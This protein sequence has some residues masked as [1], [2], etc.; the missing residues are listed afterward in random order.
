KLFKKVNTVTL[1][2]KKATVKSIK[3]ALKQMSSLKPGSLAIIFLAGHGVKDERTGKYYYLTRNSRFEKPATAGLDW[4]IFQDLLSRVKCRVVLLLD[5]CHSG[6]IS[7]ETIVRNDELVSNMLADERSGVL[8]FTA[9]K[10]RQESV[11]SPDLGT[12]EGLFTWTILEALDAVPWNHLGKKTRNLVVDA[13]GDKTIQ[14]SELMRFVTG[15]AH[16]ISGGFQTPR[17]S[18][19]EICGD[20]PVAFLEDYEPRR[21][22]GHTDRIDLV[23]FS[24]NSKL[25]A[26]AGKDHQIRLWSLPARRLH[27]TLEGHGD[28]VL[29]LA[30]TPKGKYLVSGGKDKTIRIWSLPAG[31]QR[32]KLSGHESWIQALAVSPDGK[33]LASGGGK[34]YGSDKGNSIRIW[35]LPDGKPIRT[36]QDDQKSI[37]QLAFS[38]DGKLLAARVHGLTV[39]VWSVGSWKLVTELEGHSNDVT[40]MV[41]TPDGKHLLTGGKDRRINL[42]S[43]PDGKALKTARNHEKGISSLAVSHDGRYF[44]SGGNDGAVILWSLPDCKPEKTATE[45]GYS[46]TL[47]FS[48]DSNL[49]AGGGAGYSPEILLWSIPNLSRLVTL[50]KHVDH[51]PQVAI[52]P[53]GNWLAG[54]GR[55]PTVKVWSLRHEGLR[56]ILKAKQ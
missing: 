13:N 10:G 15:R 4:K 8:I 12:G 19:Q 46:G 30:F 38:P 55:R 2:G 22:S 53:D 52:S 51:V 18:R 26:S 44:A 14:I 21:L 27:R 3:T 41:F 1:T 31:K 11:E 49:L 23:T 39:R 47:A 45:K 54:P 28:P 37:Y 25:L 48:P 32:K 5:T 33:L 34:R 35:S 40:S 56:S 43:L 29:Q 17:I 20:F 7:E 24:P 6:A 36:L 42:W 16:D 50:Y 9:A